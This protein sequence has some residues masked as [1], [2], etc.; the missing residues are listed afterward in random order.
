MWFFTGFVQGIGALIAALVV[1]ALVVFVV[2]TPVLVC[3]E[4]F[5]KY[6]FPIGLIFDMFMFAGLM[7]AWAA[8]ECR[9]G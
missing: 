7:G 8:Y 6:G 5:G 1:M 4:V 9:N 3:Q 2:A